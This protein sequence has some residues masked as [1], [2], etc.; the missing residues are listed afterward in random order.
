MIGA[1][2]PRDRAEA[3]PGFFLGLAKATHVKG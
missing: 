3:I 2:R 1:A